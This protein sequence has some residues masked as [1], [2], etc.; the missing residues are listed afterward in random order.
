LLF[1]RTSALIVS[2]KVDPELLSPGVDRWSSLSVE[3]NTADATWDL[4][5]FA[6]FLA[7]RAR[8]S[9]DD[10]DLP[11]Q[12]GRFVIEGELGVGGMGRVLAA[13]DPALRRSVALKIL[14]DPRGATPLR[15]SRFVAEARLTSQLEHPSI[16]PVYETG[17]SEDGLLYFVMRRVDGQSLRDLLEQ[18]RAGRGTD[19]WPL[20]R[21]IGV[22]SRIC[23]AVAYAHDRGVIHRD[24]KPSNVMLGDFGEVLVMDWGLARVG[25]WAVEPPSTDRSDPGEDGDTLDGVVVGT[26]GYM[27]PEQSAGQHRIVDERSD[28]WSLGAILYELLCLR[29]PYPIG[30]PSAG[31][32]EFW[33]PPDDPRSRVTGRNVPVE[34][35]DAAL[36]ALA[37]RRSDRTLSTGHLHRAVEAWLDGSRRLEQ[38]DSH[39]AAARAAW[40]THRSGQGQEAELRARVA[41]LEVDVPAWAPLD[42]PNK[43]E[44]IDARERLAD[45]GERVETAFAQAV[46]GAERARAFAPDHPEARDLLAEAYWTRFQAAE[47][48]GDRRAQARYS[49][50]VL[51]YDSGAY[52]PLLR[53]TGSLTLD[54]S[55]SGAD[56][57]CQRYQQRGLVWTL[58]EPV[59]LGR[60]PLRQVPLEMGSYLL[61]LK[62]PGRPDVRYPV[63]IERG[64][65]WAVDSQ[66]HLPSEVPDGFVF[67]PGGPFVRG[68]DPQAS[69]AE[70]RQSDAV[71]G[72]L[73]AR[74]PV[75]LGEY[76]AFLNDLPEGEAAA[77]APR[78]TGE[79]E[80]A[81]GPLL[82]LEDDG[83]Q[84]PHE[85]NEG[86]RWREDWPVFAVSQHDAVA[87]AAS[88]GARLPS[89]REWEK[90]ARG[91]DGRRYPWGDD[92]DAA[93]CWMQQS[94]LSDVKPK[95]IAY[96]QHDVSPYGVC[97]LAGGIRDWCGDAGFQG[98]P[99]D[100]PVRGG[101]WS[102]S[103]RLSRAANRF[104]HNAGVVRTY[105][106]FRLAMDL[107]S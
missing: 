57:V 71:D 69:F 23:E 73:I 42:H 63:A 33:P 91:V 34:L 85:D 53:G 61:T 3:S 28:V 7:T 103:A 75:T 22:F 51:E 54:T 47:A 20:R 9:S 21:L 40:R 4:G 48:A 64:G 92:F 46:S 80:S 25:E 104:M 99:D 50:R 82:R 16:V 102:G 18:L 86:D 90:A 95:P 105:L 68:G 11:E 36:G 38:A 14:R 55:P 77:R 62:M 10:E 45:I 76:I 49:Q 89:E 59:A 84:M 65:R 106:G 52:A 58:D 1:E 17:C 72:F 83:W 81:E 87:Y 67:V 29:R 35:A 5:S 94:G 107:P 2:M 88:R 44:L 15:L 100:R 27:S 39:L 98:N 8:P 66:V 74:F 26:P 31:S 96:A 6:R 56:V 97:D 101:C 30:A 24:L 12:I 43:A 60:T 70:P 79:D 32:G 13:R 93:L 19:R 78:M 41:R 37:P